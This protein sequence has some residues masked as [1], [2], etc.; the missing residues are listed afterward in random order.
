MPEGQA[1]FSLTLAKPWGSPCQSSCPRRKPDCE[2]S[3]P[4]AGLTNPVDMIHIVRTYLGRRKNFTGQRFWAREAGR[5]CIK[6]EGRDNQW[7]S[8]GRSHNC[9]NDCHSPLPG[10]NNDEVCEG[11][12]VV[13]DPSENSHEA[14][15]GWKARKIYVKLFICCSGWRGCGFDTVVHN[16]RC[17]FL[18]ASTERTCTTYGV[19]SL[20]LLATKQ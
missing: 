10:V 13:S 11:T 5:R 1:L 14:G 6:T 9:S 2:T 20:S 15:H 18:T 16:T 8:Y 4:Q 19:K 3:Y 12:G 7:S 17:R